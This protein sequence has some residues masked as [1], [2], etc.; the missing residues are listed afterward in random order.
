MTGADVACPA[1]VLSTIHN[2]QSQPRLSELTIRSWAQEGGCSAV[3]K[4]FTK[5]RSAHG[6]TTPRQPGHT[7]YSVL[8][9]YNSLHIIFLGVNQMGA[10]VGDTE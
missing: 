6:S 10:E 1:V 8:V 5:L 7:Q 4:M 3:W 2:P 9:L